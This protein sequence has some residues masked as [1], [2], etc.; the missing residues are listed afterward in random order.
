MRVNSA[1][2]ALQRN[3]DML[4]SSVIHAQKGVL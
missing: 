4:I 2:N 1:M 3:L